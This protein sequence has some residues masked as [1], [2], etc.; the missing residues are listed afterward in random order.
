MLPEMELVSRR[1]L[2]RPAS[3][4]Q[5]RNMA[6]PYYWFIGYIY[7]MTVDGQRSLI[8]LVELKDFDISCYSGKRMLYDCQSFAYNGCKI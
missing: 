8:T 2:G 6:I 3:F 5:W 1:F 4:L 7:T